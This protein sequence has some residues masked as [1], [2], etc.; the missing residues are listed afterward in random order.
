[1]PEAALKGTQHTRLLQFLGPL[2]QAPCAGCQ[3][4]H[5]AVPI[6]K[7]RVAGMAGGEDS[8][9]A[10]GTLV[11]AHARHTRAAAAVAR[12]TV[13]LRCIY[14]TRVTVTGC[15]Q[16]TDHR[17]RVPVEHPGKHPPT[18][19]GPSSPLTAALQPRV[20][21]VELLALRTGPPAET[22]TAVALACELEWEQAE[23]NQGQSSRDRRQAAGPA[24][25]EI[26][27]KCPTS[28]Q[29]G[30]LARLGWQAQGWQPRP[31]VRFQKLGAQRSQL[32]PW[33]LGRHGHCPL[34]GSQ[35]QRSVDGHCRGSV[36]SRLQVQPVPA[37]MG[38]PVKGHAPVKGSPA[39]QYP[40]SPHSR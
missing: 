39:R 7:A 3:I 29:V 31:L 11:A 35:W 16:R 26:H 30:P 19:S 34:L 25:P 2:L 23:V 9:E 5:H 17:V 24:H 18:H 1:M 8:R 20:S 10:T 15:G 37:E 22:S 40:P 28:L 32:R 33:T 12:G 27:R 6:P 13:T 21:P 38:T 4:L 14:P 36:P